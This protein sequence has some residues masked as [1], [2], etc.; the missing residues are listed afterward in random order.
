MVDALIGAAGGLASGI[1]GAVAGNSQLKKQLNAQREENEKNRRFNRQLAEQQNEW[2]IAQ[3][4]RENAYNDPAAMR[5][6]L[7]AAGFNPNLAVSGLSGT[8]NAAQSPAMTAGAPS[9]PTDLSALG[10]MDNPI[11][12]GIQGMFQGLQAENLQAQTEKTKTEVDYQKIVNQYLP[13]QISANLKLSKSQA[14]E[15]VER[16]KNY[17]FQANEINA[18]IIKYEQEANSAKAQTRQSM[19]FGDYMDALRENLDK[20]LTLDWYRETNYVKYWSKE[21]DIEAAKLAEVCRQ[22]DFN[23]GLSSG[24]IGSPQELQAELM[25]TARSLGIKMNSLEESTRWVNFGLDK[26]GQVMDIAKDAVTTFHPGARAAA[27][28]GSTFDSVERFYGSFNVKK[29]R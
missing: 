3:W 29:K 12:A 4:N 9:A 25:R 11:T 13:S 20:R 10:R 18:R 7:E 17:Q 19:K 15:I 26:V 27:A 5:A 1:V 28:A 24:E 22:F 14:M 6:R 21:L 8:L 2:N 23:V 16:S